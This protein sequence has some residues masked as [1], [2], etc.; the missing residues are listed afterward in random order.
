MP[1]NDQQAVEWLKRAA[2]GITE[3]QYWYGRML[4][5]G[6]GVEV[7]LDE[8]RFW[9]SKAAELGHQLAALMLDDASESD[10]G[11]KEATA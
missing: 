11:S 6:R 8:A 3:A 9:F 4:A 1:R 5:E 2:E 10:A 7:D